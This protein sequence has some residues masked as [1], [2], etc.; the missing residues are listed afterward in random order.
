MPNTDR[1]S[2][3]LRLDAIRELI[4]A[5]EED[6]NDFLHL[7]ANETVLSPFARKV[8]SSE[9]GSRYLLEH[10][11]MRQDS[12]SRLNNLLYR[13]MNHVNQVEKSATEVCERM[14]GAEYAEFRCLSGLHAMQTTFAALTGPG[15]KIMRI[16]TKDGG[17][18]LT[19]MIC[20]TF[21]RE[22]CTYAFRDISEID[23]DATAAIF[24]RERPSLLYIDAMNYLFPFPIREL[25]DLIGDVPLVYDASHTLGL[26][27]GKRFQDPLA[28]GADILQ[29]N[30]HKTFFGPQKGLIVGND[31]GLMERISYTLSNGMVSSQ[32]TAST[33][34]L[35]IALH[36]MYEVGEAYADQVLRNAKKLATR[37]DELGVP[38]LAKDR[39]FTANHM[40][41]VDTRDLG[42]GPP[43]IDRLIA[44][45]ISANRAVAFDHVDALRLGVQEITR[46][47]GDEDDMDRIAGWL[48]DVLL[49]KAK[50]EDVRPQVRTFARNHQTIRFTGGPAAEPTGRARH[51][52]TPAHRQGGRWVE[53]V[54]RR[55]PVDHSGHRAT[56]EESR[57]LARL[58]GAFA[59]QT[60]SAGNVSFS[61]GGKLYVSASGSYIK[62]LGDEDF[63]QVEAVDE[64]VLHCR[65]SGPASVEAYLHYLLATR[66]SAKFVV[67]NHYIPDAHL[68]RL[69][70]RVIEPQEYGSVALATAVAR[71]AEDAKKIYVR[72][73]GLV[74][75]SETFAEARDLIS[76]LSAELP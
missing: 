62:D 1:T 18:F 17:H 16:S 54:L 59:H 24:R 64:G 40:M 68:T 29:A 3:P 75:W 2:A 51:R 4:E 39:G 76:G 49:G 72:R 53:T 23:L 32:H 65:G 52:D 38:M 67:H 5:E 27:A 42:G 30:T 66:L 34:A 50:P 19:E 69:G 12:P 74:F 45:G 8:L 43:L 21:G 37:L 61:A 22:S 73:H 58:G 13:G 15:E 33:L 28:E 41:F 35:F 60:D 25:K 11:D 56:L 31:R 26:I 14:F 20:R 63:V 55:D 47:S 36:E 57:A 48:A 6:S 70:V 9:L 71:A 10:L 7:T 44:A 46:R